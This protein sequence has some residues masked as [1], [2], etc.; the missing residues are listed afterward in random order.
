MCTPNTV[1]VLDLKNDTHQGCILLGLS[2]HEKC[3]LK[4]T[5][6]TKCNLCRSRLKSGSQKLIIKSEDGLALCRYCWLFLFKILLILQRRVCVAYFLKKS[7]DVNQVSPGPQVSRKTRWTT[8]L[9]THE[10]AS[11]Q[12]FLRLSSLKLSNESM[13]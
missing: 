3:L 5:S 13:N 8:S 2:F 11:K 7:E 12:T 1:T 4:A 9:M 6:K 10:I